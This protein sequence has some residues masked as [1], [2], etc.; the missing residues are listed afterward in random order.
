MN[1]GVVGRKGRNFERII[2][3]FKQLM[4]MKMSEEIMKVQ[5]EITKHKMCKIKFI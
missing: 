5:I 2:L 1:K 4:K 3:S